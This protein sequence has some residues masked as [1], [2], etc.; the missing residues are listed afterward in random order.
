MIV[1]ILVFNELINDQVNKSEVK[2]LYPF[3]Y[4]SS[5][6][7]KS[8]LEEVHS[9]INVNYILVSSKESIVHI[10]SNV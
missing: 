5:F 10:F 8:N 4:I 7:R 2:M 6:I 3:I 1:K 9:R